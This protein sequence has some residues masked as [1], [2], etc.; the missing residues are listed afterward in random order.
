VA[1]QQPEDRGGGEEGVGD[2][3]AV[4]Y[5]KGH[6]QL[7]VHLGHQQRVGGDGRGAVEVGQALK[8]ELV[9]CISG[10]DGYCGTGHA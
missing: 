5:R 2:R 1:A 8:G 9:V 3:V 7:A 4:V 10:P 6:A